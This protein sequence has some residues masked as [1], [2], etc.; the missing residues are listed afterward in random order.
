[1]KR[2]TKVVGVVVLLAFLTTM[3]VPVVLSFSRKPAA[4]STAQYNDVHSLLKT[5]SV[6]GFNLVEQRS[7]SR[8]L[9]KATSS[10]NPVE[11][12][13]FKLSHPSLE[14][15]V[16]TYLYTYGSNTI[17]ATVLHDDNAMVDVK[18]R[19]S[20]SPLKEAEDLKT[21]ILG[22]FPDLPCD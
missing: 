2:R 12:W 9:N 5:A 6:P 16:D 8:K 22:R 10:M 14:H 11:R 7:I 20:P 13:F 15:D 18:I 21:A 19:S 3:I 4:Y 1:M 17:T